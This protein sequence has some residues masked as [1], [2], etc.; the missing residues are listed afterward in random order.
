MTLYMKIFL[1]IKGKV[2]KPEYTTKKSYWK[3][4]QCGETFQN[5]YKHYVKMNK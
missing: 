5:P 3:C 2:V 1:F 4:C